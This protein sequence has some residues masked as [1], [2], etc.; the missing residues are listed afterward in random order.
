MQDLEFFQKESSQAVLEKTCE[1]I[2]KI[3]REEY[4]RIEKNKIIP[5]PKNLKI[6]VTKIEEV[7]LKLT[8]IMLRNPPG[9]FKIDTEYL[10]EQSIKL[11]SLLFMKQNKLKTENIKK[12]LREKF[13]KLRNHPFLARGYKISSDWTRLDKLRNKSIQMMS[14]PYLIM[15]EEWIRGDT[16][17]D[18]QA[19]DYLTGKSSFSESNL[20]S[21]TSSSDSSE[22]ISLMSESISFDLISLP[23]ESSRYPDSYLNES[24][25]EYQKEYCAIE[26]DKESNFLFQSPPNQ[27]IFEDNQLKYDLEENMIHNDSLIEMTCLP[28]FTNSKLITE[29]VSFKAQIS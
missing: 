19:L 28:C 24:F 1:G 5:I 16:D 26:E 12:V 22:S 2:N 4:V 20:P 14:V 7:I 11:C 25:D 29:N 21:S 15:K 27:Y 3:L 8:S 18:A 23:D 13:P 17:S 6:D 10:I 9:Q